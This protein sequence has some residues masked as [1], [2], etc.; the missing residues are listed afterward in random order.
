[1]RI[2]TLAIVFVFVV[3]G[4]TAE[5]I[6]SIDQGVADANAIAQTIGGLPGSPAGPLIPAPI[7]AILELVGIGGA[8]AYGIW[9]N[10]RKKLLQNANDRL[11]LTGKAIV[12]GVDRAPPNT[13]EEVKALISAEMDRL[14]IRDAGRATVKELKQG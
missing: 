2:H 5:Q 1:M 10:A 12:A 4:C 14:A 9:Q 7:R 8:A 6:A 13:A 11:K 3:A